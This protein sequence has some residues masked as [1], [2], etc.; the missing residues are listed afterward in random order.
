[1]DALL[2]S[3]RPA[4]PDAIAKCL[5]RTLLLPFVPSG[6]P[7]PGIPVLPP[8]IETNLNISVTF[9]GD[10]QVSSNRGAQSETVSNPFSALKNYTPLLSGGN[11]IMKEIIY[12]LLQNSSWPRS[13]K[14]LHT[15][16]FA[17]LD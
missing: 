8:P 2:Q 16:N 11:T 9:L 6:A 4:G 14:E 7:T 13:F 15:I 3:R 5:S 17:F 10:K 12:Y 1:V